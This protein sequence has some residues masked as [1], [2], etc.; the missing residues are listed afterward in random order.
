MNTLYFETALCSL[1]GDRSTNQDRTLLLHHA[2]T[3]LLALADGLGG[4]PRGDVAAQLLTDVCEARFRQQEKPLADPEDFILDC[5]L[6][7]HRAIER[8]GTR[9]TPP[10]DPRTTAVLALVQ[11]GTLYWAHVGDSRLYL[12][13]AGNVRAQSRDHSLAHFIRPSTGAASAARASVTRC[14]GGRA[15]P[16]VVTPGIPVEL[17]PNDRL[18]LCSDGL[19]GQ[20]AQ[21]ELIDAVSVSED[22][23]TTLQDLAA[24]AASGGHPNSDN[25]SLLALWWRP[26]AAPH[27]LAPPA[28]TPEHE[29]HAAIHHLRGVIEQNNN[30]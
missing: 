23:D 7:A 6:R 14:L 18:L 11:A 24:R 3:T 22:F 13:R 28:P 20:V 15:K 25:V 5:L 27:Q 17:E 2:G 1:V 21:D 10:I 12:I 16:P 8:F 30:T 29:F 4:H 9:Q 19:W 26:R